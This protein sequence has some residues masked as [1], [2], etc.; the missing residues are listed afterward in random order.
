MKCISAVLLYH[1]V[2]YSNSV[3]Q[4][5]IEPAPPAVEAWSPNHQT[6]MEAPF[7]RAVFSKV[8][9]LGGVG[10]RARGLKDHHGLVASMAPGH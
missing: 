9:T 1:R 10:G 8:C 2:V 5:G 7:N 6:V 3:A 4:L